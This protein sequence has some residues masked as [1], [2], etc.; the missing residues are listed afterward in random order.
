VHL[1]GDRFVNQSGKQQTQAEQA[2]RF[3]D[4]LAG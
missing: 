4:E 2:L 1:E 3:C